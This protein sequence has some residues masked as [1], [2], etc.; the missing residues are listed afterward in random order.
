V[1]DVPLRVLEV[2]VR[3]LYEALKSYWSRGYRCLPDEEGNW[4]CVRRMNEVQE[5]GSWLS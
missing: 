4:E 3:E 5:I 2:G 1:L